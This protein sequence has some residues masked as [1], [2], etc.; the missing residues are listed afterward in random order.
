MTLDQWAAIAEILSSVVIA[1]TLIYLV[2]QTRQNASAIQAST[3]HAMVQTDVQV[4]MG[5]LSN[6]TSQAM[7]IQNPSDDEL[8]RLESWLVALVRTREHQWFQL[9]NGL[10]DRRAFDA[11]LS[12]LTV[13]LSHPRTRKWWERVKYAY[14]DRGFVDEVSG[15]ISSTPI[16][17]QIRPT[18]E[19]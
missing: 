9:Q 5:D 6:P 2:I 11:Y 12:G 1:V 13:N 14:F 18:I 3:R 8:N 19:P 16:S 7:Y 17:T 15:P 4:L 10:L